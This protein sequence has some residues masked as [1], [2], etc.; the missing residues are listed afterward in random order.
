MLSLLFFSI[1]M[2]VDGDDTA[3]PF[4][5]EEQYGS[6]FETPSTSTMSKTISVAIGAGDGGFAPSPVEYISVSD[7][8]LRGGKL[9]QHHVY[10]I[11]YTPGSGT[12][13]EAVYRRYSDFCWLYDTLV[14]LYP[15][16]FIPVLPPKK[17]FGKSDEFLLTQRRPGLQRFLNVVRAQP[18]LVD[19]TPFQMFMMRTSSF[20]EG[21]SD[22][23]KQLASRN[24]RAVLD[25]Y[26]YY[27]GDV[28][29]KPVTASCE[30]EINDMMQLFKTERDRLSELVVFTDQLVTAAATT[31]SLISKIAG[32]AEKVYEAETACTSIPV[33]R[34]SLQSNFN[35]WQLDNKEVEASYSRNLNDQFNN[36]LNDIKVMIDL[37]SERE[38]LKARA[39]KAKAKANK[40]LSSSA[41]ADT[42]K[43]RLQ[44]DIDVKADEDDNALLEAVTK[45]IVHCQFKF[46]WTLKVSEFN[47]NMTSFAAAQS[48]YARRAYQN[49]DN[50]NKT[51]D[52]E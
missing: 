33:Q 20:D 46:M 23:K 35:D 19:S 31:S 47:E 21:K 7:P 13:G 8:E 22:M 41:K 16:V 2:S 37:I 15:G 14:A 17:V 48:L 36:E 25:A 39:E 4:S 6:S 11:A 30:L 18:I 9:N 26:T 49:W 40:W 24:T 10:K 50:V 45:M 1:G 32:A 43:Q 34:A 29:R 42:D 5:A 38:K 51:E 52:D 28:M 3:N 12:R 27:Y 44:K